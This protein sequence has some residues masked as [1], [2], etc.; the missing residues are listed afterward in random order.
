MAVCPYCH[1]KVTGGSIVKEDI[2]NRG[3]MPTI[4]ARIYSCPHC[5]KILGV[6]A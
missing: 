2:T 5:K 3:F 1:K 6:F 4:E